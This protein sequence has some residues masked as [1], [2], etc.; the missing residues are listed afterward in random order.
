MHEILYVTGNQIK[1]RVASE[2][3]RQFKILL[4]HTSLDIHEIQAEAGEPVARDKADKAYSLLQKPLVV[5]DDTWI[6]PGLNGFPGPYMKSV[7]H[8]FSR[9]DWLRLTSDLSNRRIIL[10][11]IVVYQDADGQKLFYTDIEGMLLKKLHEASDYPHLS[12]TSFDGGKTSISEA[13][14]EGES[15]I[16]GADRRTSWHD[17]AEWYNK[18]HAK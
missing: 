6:I 14:N 11:Q 7:N 13:V 17:F 3:C 9:E 18:T 16:L 2:V 12:I 4:T 10:R 1:I 5:S 15:A 8:W